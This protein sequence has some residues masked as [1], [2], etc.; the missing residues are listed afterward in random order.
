MG[1]GSHILLIHFPNKPLSLQ[2]DESMDVGEEASSEAS[3]IEMARAPTTTTT[4]TTQTSAKVDDY[5]VIEYEGELNPGR[6][7]D[8]FD[9]GVQVS[10]LAKCQGIGWKWPHPK[11]VLHYCWADVQ[12]VLQSTD[13]TSVNKRGFS[14]IKCEMLEKKWDA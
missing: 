7:L 13:V 4:N 5:V 3:A 12:C 1:L 11:D 14:K 8:L 9:G 10:T 2:N 6:V